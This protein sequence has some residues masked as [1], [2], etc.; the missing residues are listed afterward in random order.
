MIFFTSDLHFQ[1]IKIL[2]YEPGRKFAN[3]TDMNV[4]LINNWNETINPA[5][6]VYIIGDFCMGDRNKA[7]YFLHSLNG[8]KHLIVGN[9]DRQHKNNQVYPQLL[10]AFSP[11]QVHDELTIDHNGFKL[12]MR[13]E[14]DMA[15]KPESDPHIH[16]AG[17]VHSAW[18]RIGSI[19]NVGVDV[20]GLRPMTLS[21]LLA[22]PN[23]AGKVHREGYG[24]TSTI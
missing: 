16:L 24:L 4:G 17:H 9:H 14:P 22:R 3:L 5:D 18:T 20:C 2:E 15:F 8:E 11:D 7:S 6:T 19:L 12:Y 23:V 21:Q 13:H 10:E 1:H